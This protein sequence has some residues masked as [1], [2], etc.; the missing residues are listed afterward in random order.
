MQSNNI[1]F[2]FARDFKNKKRETDGKQSA[3]DFWQEQIGVVKLDG[4]TIEQYLE[5]RKK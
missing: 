3:Y 1:E 4:K 5:Y 2:E